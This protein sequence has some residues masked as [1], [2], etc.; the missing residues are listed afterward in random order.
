MWHFGP[1][2]IKIRAKLTHGKSVQTHK[3]EICLESAHKSLNNSYQLICDIAKWERHAWSFEQP[4]LYLHGTVSGLE[5]HQPRLIPLA[6]L[7][8]SH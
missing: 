8:S 6:L 3:P 2:F 7:F 1:K 4:Q 5:S